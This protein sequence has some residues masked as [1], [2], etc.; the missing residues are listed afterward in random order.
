MPSNLLFSDQF[1]SI[2]ENQ[3]AENIAKNSFF[4]YE[5]AINPEIINKMLSETELFKINF[6]STAISSVYANDGYY[7][8]NAIT[9]SHTVFKFL[10]S[11]KIFGIA[12]SYLGNEFRLK[13]HRIYSLSP[14]T[15]QGWHTDNRK[16]GDGNI[17]KINGLVFIVYLNDV[18]NGEFQAIKGS[19]LISENYKYADYNDDVI[20]D[21]SKD[22]VSFKL[23]LGSIIIFD[24]RAIHRAKPYY[25]LLWRRKSL[26]FQVDTE[27]DDA[28]KLL[29]NPRFIN[30]MDKT[31]FTY[32]GMG[33]KND[34][35]QEPSNS[36][37]KTLN[38]KDIANVQG[39]LF[40]AI[41]Y[42]IN[43][44]LRNLFVSNKIK[45]GIKKLLKIK[46]P[47]NTK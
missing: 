34:M 26:F 45:V 6:N 22:I 33:K 43:W 23:P 13:C 31:L 12:R 15:R 8:S 9:K 25:N 30:N 4:S 46:Q 41:L 42:R 17:I 10:T 28:E 47:I 2:P 32:L 11:K 37:I 36:E 21:Y 18:F 3:I 44:L 39:K 1:D 29:I 16:T 20:K 24:I 19:H 7:N 35:P 40:L 27:L 14:F 5:K 38:F